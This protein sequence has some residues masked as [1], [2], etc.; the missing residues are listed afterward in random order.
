MVDQR[1]KCTT[2]DVTMVEIRA[3]LSYDCLEIFALF[4]FFAE[5]SCNRA[6]LMTPHKGS[7]VVTHAAAV[8]T[9]QDVF[10]GD[11]SECIPI[12]FDSRKFCGL[13]KKFHV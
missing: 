9:D 10:D 11:K 4:E 12:A 8:S 3:A 7:S 5:L 6:K 2:V 13:N 1:C